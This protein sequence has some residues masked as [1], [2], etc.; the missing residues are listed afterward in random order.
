MTTAPKK[1]HEAWSGALEFMPATA[2]TLPLNVN[3]TLFGLVRKQRNESFKTVDADGKIMTGTTTYPATPYKGVHIGGPKS[4][5]NAK[6]APLDNDVVDAIRDSQKT[7]VAKPEQFVPV[8]DIDL[9]LAID[10]FVV[11]P[12]ADVPGAEQ[13]VQIVWNGLRAHR[14]AWVSQVTLSSQDALLVIYA[15]G[16]DLRAVLLPFVAELYPVPEFEFVEDD[17]AE[18]LFGKVVNSAHGGPT[19]FEHARFASKYQAR[20]EELLAQ[21]VAGQFVVPEEPEIVEDDTPDLMAA[22]EASL[23][24][25]EVPA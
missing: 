24:Q 25:V 21:A 15:T 6:Y 20:K 2:S 18:A 22:L 12:D 16:T 17:K 9:T 3:V 10:R 7:V 4:G 1:P 14:M 11:R 13:G 8:D 5:P 19:N 23:E